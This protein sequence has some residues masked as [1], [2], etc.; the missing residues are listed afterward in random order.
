VTA[1]LVLLEL[2]LGLVLLGVAAVPL[3]RLRAERAVGRLVT[4]EP[5]GTRLLQSDRYRLRGRPDEVR[6]RS[7]GSLVPVEYKHR[8]AP[9]RRAFFAHTVQVWAYCLLLEEATGRPP[10]FGIVRYTDRDDRVPWNPEAKAALVDLTRR[11]LGPYDGSAAP[12]VGKCRQCAWSDRCDASLA[13]G[14]VA[15]ASSRPR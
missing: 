5:D 14:V 4:V 2:V 8:E 12:T 13:A 3:L 9:V 10:P 11:A 6:R 7:D 15:S 1:P